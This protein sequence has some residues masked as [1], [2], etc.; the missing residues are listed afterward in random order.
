[1][2][3]PEIDLLAIERGSVSA[4]AGC[5]KTHVVAASLGRYGGDKPILILTHTNAGV[6]ALRTRLIRAGVRPTAYRLATLDGWAIRLIATFPKRSGHDPKILDLRRPSSDYPAIRLAAARLLQFGHLS[7][8]L[9][10]SYDRLL[11]DEYQDCLQMQHAIVGLTAQVLPTC[12]LGDPLQAI[13]GFAGKLVHW[14]NDVEAT[15]PPAG[16]LSTPWRWINAGETAFGEWLLAAR[17]RLL[18]GQPVDLRSAP[19]NVDW[20]QLDG[21]DD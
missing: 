6:M 10:S 19:A 1:L 18:A 11:V 21:T 13:F 9:V 7:D 16:R 15:F 14:K 17:N 12:V 8:V 2:I 5:G 3:E 4:P 20:V